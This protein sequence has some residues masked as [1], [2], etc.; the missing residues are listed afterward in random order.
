M[1]KDFGLRLIEARERAQMTQEQAAECLD[2][3]TRMLSRYEGNI[4]RPSEKTMYRMMEVYGDDSLGY[5][6]LRLSSVGTKILPE[7]NDSSLA[8]N[9]LG[10][11][12]GMKKSRDYLS[13]LMEIGADNK[14]TA[15]EKPK[16][17][18]AV[19]VFRLITKNW[20]SLRFF[21]NS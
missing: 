7:M 3:S 16:Y 10:L 20:L 19:N 15:N 2:I 8:E 12:V 14:I 5:H 21:H 4:C 9:I 17:I 18:Q 13:D 1:S 11:I 6:W